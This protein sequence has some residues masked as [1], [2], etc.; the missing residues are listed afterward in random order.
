M[1]K[2]Y[3]SI[4]EF[5]VAVGMTQ[6]GVYKQLNKKLKPYLKVVDNKKMLDKS[7][8]ELFKNDRSSQQVEQPLNRGEQQLNNKLIEMLQK[9]LEE[10]GE[11][12]K[13]KDRQIERLQQSIDQA[14]KLHAMDKQRILELEC[15]AEEPTEPTEPQKKKWWNIFG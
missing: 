5:A 15:K 8:I 6:Q 3:I 7:A 12:L 2:E 1:K 10:K 11:Q 4:K 14:Q 13:E 9:E